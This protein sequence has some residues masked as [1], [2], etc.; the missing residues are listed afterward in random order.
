MIV[1]TEFMPL[2]VAILNLL[3]NCEAYDLTSESSTL[4]L[5]STKYVECRHLLKDSRIETKCF[6]SLRASLFMAGKR[7]LL[8]RL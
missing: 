1:N 4:R 3:S 5:P 6:F 8:R 2:P 7:L